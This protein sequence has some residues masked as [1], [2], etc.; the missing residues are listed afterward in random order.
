MRKRKEKSLF[1]N[2]KITYYFSHPQCR[3]WTKAGDDL[4]LCSDRGCQQDPCLI[5][6]RYGG[7]NEGE[8]CRERESVFKAAQCCLGELISI[9]AFVTECLLEAGHVTFY[10]CSLSVRSSCSGCPARDFEVL[11]A[12]VLSTH[13]CNGSQWELY[14]QMLEN[15]RCFENTSPECLKSGTKST[16]NFLNL[17]SPCF[18][19]LGIMKTPHFQEV[20]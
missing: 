7:I 16:G 8:D 1:F 6:Q 12:E 13:G 19:K 11:L 17:I 20:L 3:G 2:N 9:P 5:L 14:F 4:G 15:I 18:C 10:R